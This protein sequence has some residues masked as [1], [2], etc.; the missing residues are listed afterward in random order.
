[1]PPAFGLR[2]FS[3]AFRVLYS[4]T[5]RQA[6]A[7]GGLIPIM[8]KHEGAICDLRSSIEYSIVVYVV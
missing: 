6:A 2:S 5:Q 1:M 4:P 3:F 7:A 8:E